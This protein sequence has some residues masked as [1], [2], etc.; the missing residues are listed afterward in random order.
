MVFM[1]KKLLDDLVKENA[2]SELIVIGGKAG[3]GKSILYEQLVKH[4]KA[5]E[6][7]IKSLQP[8][9]V[10]NDDLVAYEIK[11]DGSL[12]VDI[13]ETLY[14][15]KSKKQLT[16]AQQ[17]LLEAKLRKIKNSKKK[18]KKRK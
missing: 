12:G 16:K 11:E 2:D 17:M 3:V 6:L 9:T 14:T 1:S 15:K 10:E 13:T 4:Q 8:S 18:R 7:D 5:M